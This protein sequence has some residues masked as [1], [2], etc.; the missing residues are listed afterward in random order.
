[1]LKVSGLTVSVC[2]PSEGAALL[3][4]WKIGLLRHVGECRRDQ[5]RKALEMRLLGDNQSRGF[6]DHLSIRRR[7]LCHRKGAPDGLHPLV[8]LVGRMACDVDDVGFQTVGII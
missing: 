4:I 6:T 1:M 7:H 3:W 8:N 2:L 5:L